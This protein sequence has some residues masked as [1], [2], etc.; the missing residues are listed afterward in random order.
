MYADSCLCKGVIICINMKNR[1]F[2]QFSALFIRINIYKSS[3]TPG[4]M[5]RGK[6]G[7]SGTLMF[8]RRPA[9]EAAALS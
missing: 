4:D 7:V 8:R 2:M 1:L 5:R 6:K 3:K 9:A